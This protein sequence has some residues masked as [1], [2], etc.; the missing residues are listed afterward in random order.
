MSTSRW[1]RPAGTVAA[2]AAL[3]AAAPLHITPTVVLA[4]HVDVIRTTLAGASQY[5]ER[6]VDIG[7]DDLGRIRQAGNFT[8]EGGEFDFYYGT[9]A[10]GAIAGVVLFPQVNNQHGPLEVGIAVGP[11]GAIM[12][13]IVTKATV[14]TKPWVQRAVKAGFLRAFE[15]LRRPEDADRALGALS[16]DEIGAMPYYMAEQ[17]ALAVR[18]GLVLYQVL[19]AGT[20][21][22]AASE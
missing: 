18:R 10:A 14:E 9:N 13:V 17:T 8:P 7:R 22:A 19:F 11:D 16:R 4:K 3:T 21:S 5:F 15:G 6:T 1:L 2:I 12:R 20:G